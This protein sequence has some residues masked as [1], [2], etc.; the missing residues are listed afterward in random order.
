MIELFSQ[1]FL[2]EPK[3][4]PRHP[5]CRL[6]ARIEICILAEARTV[7]L[8]EVCIGGV[9]DY[10]RLAVFI[11][12][13]VRHCLCG[14]LAHNARSSLHIAALHRI[15]IGSVINFSNAHPRAVRHFCGVLASAHLNALEP[16]LRDLEHGVHALGVVDAPRA[17]RRG[18][19]LLPCPRLE[20]GVGE[21]LRG[22]GFAD[23]ENRPSVL[24]A[25]QSL[26]LAGLLM[27]AIHGLDCVEQSRLRFG[28]LA[29]SI[30]ADVSVSVGEFAKLFK[31]YF[32]K[33]VF[34]FDLC[35]IVLQF[36][37]SRQLL[38]VELNGLIHYLLGTSFRCSSPVFG[39]FSDKF[40]DA[41]HFAFVFLV[42][43]ASLLRPLLVLRSVLSIRS[44]R[45]RI[46][47]R[48]GKF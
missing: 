5:S 17:V 25:I 44:L 29:Y 45:L 24:V 11:A 48:F 16:V 41:I 14:D 33:C 35:V 6:I 26:V 38:L 10:K 31:R 22:G 12:H 18:A 34:K 1:V 46:D 7:K 9:V 19:A 21:L 30:P 40:L 4:K 3:A 42:C 13:N 36:V 20:V 28:Q 47:W 37:S 15:H 2:V 39:L 43:G 8:R 27:E 32:V 23:L